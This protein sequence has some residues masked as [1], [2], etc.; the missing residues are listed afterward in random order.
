MVI[1][2]PD[3]GQKA[4]NPKPSM[5]REWYCL[6]VYKDTREHTFEY[7]GADKQTTKKVRFCHLSFA[8]LYKILDRI[9]EKE[10]KK[11]ERRWQNLL[12]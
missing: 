6:A 1:Y 2:H 8:F 11:K 3:K 4:T 12:V 10:K 5:Q 9:S 7:T